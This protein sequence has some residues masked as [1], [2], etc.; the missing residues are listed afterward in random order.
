MFARNLAPEDPAK[1]PGHEGTFGAGPQAVFGPRGDEFDAEAVAFRPSYACRRRDGLAP[2]IWGF[3]ADH[4][5]RGRNTL[6]ET[7]AI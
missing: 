7:G 5:A 1:P 6:D 3:G 2:V 4:G